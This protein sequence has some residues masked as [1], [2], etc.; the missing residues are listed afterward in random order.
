MG[1]IDRAFILAGVISMGVLIGVSS[2]GDNEAVEE[3][4]PTKQ[5]LEAAIEKEQWTVTYF[6]DG[7][8]ERDD[9]KGLTFQFLNDGG[10]VAIDQ[11]TTINGVWAAFDTPDGQVKFNMEFIS[12]Q[13]F[14][15][16]NDNWVVV[17]KTDSKITLEDLSDRTRDKLTLERV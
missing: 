10:F 15:K 11:G 8:S 13:P 1:T 6:F 3:V 9:L 5:A 17:E 2:C 4:K 7:K 16:L 14:E 12:E